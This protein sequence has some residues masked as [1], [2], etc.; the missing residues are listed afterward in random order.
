MNEQPGDLL[1]EAV[2]LIGTLRRRWNDTVGGA[3]ADHAAGDDRAAGGDVWSRA[4]AEAGA[5]E[6][7][8]EREA[9]P[10]IATG[11]AEC[12]DCPICRAI[13][14][15]R[16]SGADV[17]AHLREAMRSLLAAAK[18][19]AAAYER[20]RGPWGP[21]AAGRRDAGGGA[22]GGPDDDG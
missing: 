1:D 11:A 22:D 2:K 10:R 9:P 20:T 17:Q 4:V 7:S 18:E 15:S 8:R 21:R 16:E 14:V 12:R 19:V 5:A 6:R 3:A 13:A